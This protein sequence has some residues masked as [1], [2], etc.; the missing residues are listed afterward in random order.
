[1]DPT[2]PVTT[3]WSPDTFR[4][5]QNSF[6]SRVPRPIRISGRPTRSKVP[7]WRNTRGRGYSNRDSLLSRGARG[8]SS[9]RLRRRSSSQLIKTRT[10]NFTAQGLSRPLSSLS[11]GI[12]TPRRGGGRDRRRRKTPT[13][14]LEVSHTS[15]LPTV[16]QEICQR[17]HSQDP[18]VNDTPTTPPPRSRRG[19]RRTPPG[20][21]VLG[22]SLGLSVQHPRPL[23]FVS[24]SP[25]SGSFS[26]PSSPQYSSILSSLVPRY[27]PGP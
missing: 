3:D 10:G 25:V 24:V 12:K 26:E 1:M 14:R 23:P 13:P 16:D 9:E 21:I 20:L 22:V 11:L 8:W 2:L 17:R 15:R 5:S 27:P 18:D 7:D 6:N 4:P 19:C